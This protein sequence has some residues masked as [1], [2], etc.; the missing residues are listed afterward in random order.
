MYGAT[1]SRGAYVEMLAALAPAA[2]DYA[3]LFDDVAPGQDPVA[4][5]WSDMHHMP[6]GS[7]ATQWRRDR[8]LGEMLL[9]RPGQYID[10]MA[11]DTISML[12]R[13]FREWAPNQ[14]PA[15]QR[16]D[17]SVLTCPDRAVTCA[18]AKWLRE[19]VLDDGSI[20]AG[21]RYVSRHGGELSC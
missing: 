13:H 2:V 11:G 7:T 16:I 4:Q 6:P 19:Q 8:Q 1:P 3:E 12:R 17:T 10:V 20:P 18:V 9:L 5:D 14:D 21:I 15:H